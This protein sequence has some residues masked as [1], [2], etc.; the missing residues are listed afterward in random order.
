MNEQTTANVT[1]IIAA[2]LPGVISLVPTAF[3]QTN[4][5]VPVPTSDEVNA[6]FANTCATTLAVDDEYL[7]THP[8]EPV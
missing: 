5:E 3:A 8:K 2:L 7:K 4:S 1:S 6:I